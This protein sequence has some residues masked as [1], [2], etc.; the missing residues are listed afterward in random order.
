MFWQV[1]MLCKYLQIFLLM[2]MASIMISSKH[3]MVNKLQ[4]SWLTS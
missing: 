3:T 2:A 1:Y 4:D